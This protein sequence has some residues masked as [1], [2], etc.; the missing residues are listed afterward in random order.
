[1]AKERQSKLFLYFLPVYY[2]YN[3]LID[4][5]FTRGSDAGIL[6]NIVI[7]A[8]LV[9]FSLMNFYNK[10]FWYIFAWITFNILLIICNSSKV[11]FSF[12][13]FAKNIIGLLCFPLSFYF[14]SSNKQIIRFFKVL[15]A[16]MLLYLLN[17]A[18][19]NTLGWGNAYGGTDSEFAVQGGASLV[20]GS[21]SVVMALMMAPVI[22]FTIPKKNGFTIL[23]S[24]TV[25]CVFL[26]FKRTNIAALI[27]GYFIYIIA[28]K[29]YKRKA[30]LNKQGKK[31]QAQ[32]FLGIIVVVSLIMIFG[33]TIAAQFDMRS[34]KFEEDA[35]AKEGRIIEWELVNKAIF[36]SGKSSIM[37]FGKEP[38]NTPNNYGFQTD[39]NIHG[40]YSLILFSTGVIGSFLYWSMQLYIAL[41][42]FKYNG[43]R[44][45]STQQDIMLFVTYLST[46]AIWFL[47]S[48]S[49]TLSYVVL[50]SLYYMTHGM[51]LRYFWNKHRKQEEY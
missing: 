35:I 25:V 15:M 36:E 5:V 20:T 48:F 22:L 32:L 40:D 45:L 16:I 3:I 1:M 2:V 8:M 18:L 11:I 26:I 13:W 41:L 7:L 19:A 43:R 21:M 29:F 49:A 50:S 33:E 38:Y 28:V 47:F 31:R 24:I 23:W 14:I 27:I 42:V 12:T 9:Y 4:V 39:R 30:N 6:L 44:Y 46:S 34:R 10:K 17:L 37:L 51:I